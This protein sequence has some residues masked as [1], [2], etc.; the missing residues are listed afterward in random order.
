[1]AG[2]LLMVWL[3][4]RFPKKY[5]ML[6]IDLLVAGAIPCLFVTGSP[7]LM[8][9]FAILSGVALVGD[10]MIIPLITAEIFDARLLGRLL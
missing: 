2:R 3:A 10:Y 6:V 9:A 5:V 4:D 7:V 1:M 8:Y